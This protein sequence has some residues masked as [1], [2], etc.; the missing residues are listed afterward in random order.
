MADPTVGLGDQ[1]IHSALDQEANMFEPGIVELAADLDR[2]APQKDAAAERFGEVEAVPAVE[3]APP[4]GGERDRHDRH[5]GKPRDIDDTGA[6]AHCRAARPVRG[7][8]DAG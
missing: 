7:D 4:A 6:G 8:A 1:L 2:L 3:D 5:A